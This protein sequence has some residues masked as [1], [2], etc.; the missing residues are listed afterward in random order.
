[1]MELYMT[2]YVGLAPMESRAVLYDFNECQARAAHS[3]SV[4]ADVIRTGVAANGRVVTKE[5]RNSLKSWR[6]VCEYRSLGKVHGS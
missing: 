3:Q 5:Q 6:I 1:M 2:L 4:I